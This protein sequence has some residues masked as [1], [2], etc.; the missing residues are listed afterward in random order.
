M[1]RK[2]K[3]RNKIVEIGNGLATVRIYTVNRS[4]GYPHYTVAW[5]EGGRRRTRVFA[6]MDEARM[7]AQ[8]TSVRLTNGASAID[9]VTKRD[10]ELLRHC[11]RTAERFG[12]T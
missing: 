10:I 8:Q 3:R 4:N 5:K 2:K 6:A 1:A 11:E 12:V 7:I 9:E